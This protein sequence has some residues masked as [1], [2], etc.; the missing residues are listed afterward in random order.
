M[1]QQHEWSKMDRI[2]LNL[3]RVFEVIYRERNLTRAAVLLHLSQ[4]AVSHAL[5]RLREQLG[6]PLFVR[7]GR[8]VAPTL[9]ATQLAPGIQAALAGLLRSV[10]RE[11]DFD[12]LRDRRTFTLNMPEQMEPVVLPSIVAHLR[13]VAPQL[14]VRCSSVHWAELQR[15]LSAGRVD[16][17]IEIA[18]STDPELR[19]QLLLSDPLCVVAGPAFSGELSA[20]R[21]LAAEH[22][23]VT[24]RRRGICVEDL[25]LA[26]Q[27]LVRQVRQRCQHYLSAALLVAQSEWLLT[28]PRRYAELINAGLPNRL[29][30]LP[31]A[32][33][34]VNLNLYWSMQVENQAG[35]RWLREQMLTLAGSRS[36]MD[37]LRRSTI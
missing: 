14:E 29:L 33:V 21:Y 31:L 3:F 8:G 15:E 32:L 7:E 16:L 23:A 1:N 22:I 37:Q 10:T 28:M 12:P 4:S 11:Q 30:D 6:D 2:D 20:A 35:H 25:A 19:Q 5:N 17:A 9:L 36:G 13:E 26:R 18:R 24:S 34:P 27:G